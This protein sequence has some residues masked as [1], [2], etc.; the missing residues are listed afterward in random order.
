VAP[1][2]ARLAPPGG[3][4]LSWS[5][6]EAGAPELAREGRVRFE[7]TH[8][9][10]LGTNRAD[11]TPRISPVEPFVIEGQLVFGVMRSPKL[12]DLQR[13]PRLVLHSSVSD[14]NGSEGEFKVYGRAIATEEP[15]IRNH[16]DAWWAAR[17]P[18]QSAV[19]T[20]D[21]TEAVLVAWSPEFDRMRTT[22]WTA[23]GD[24]RE[25]ERAYP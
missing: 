13:D 9:A 24:A 5:D 14:S 16:A 23:G 6:L 18:E 12:D 3:G 2:H 22:R 25:A 15:A 4:H 11:G 21:I 17:P 19:F 20:V 10:L 8:V 7:R 1:R